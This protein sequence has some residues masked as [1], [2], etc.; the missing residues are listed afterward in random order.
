MVVKQMQRAAE[1]GKASRK[2]LLRCAEERIFFL[3]PDDLSSRLASKNMQY[4]LGKMLYASHNEVFCVFGPDASI[5][6][7]TSRWESGFGYGCVIK[8]FDEGIA[9]PELRP[10]GCG[11]A[12]ARLEEQPTEEEIIEGLS[13][14]E[15]DPPE[16][17]G[18]EVRPDLGEGNHFFEIYRAEYIHREVEKTLSTHYYAILHCSS[19]ERKADIYG[20]VIEGDWID[21]PLGRV[22]VLLDREARDYLRLWEDYKSFCKRRRELILSKVLPDGEVIL[23]KTH[24]GIFGPAEMRLG[25]YSAV[26]GNV[27]GDIFPLTLRSDLP[28][29][30]MKGTRNLSQGVMKKL[31]FLERARGLDLLEELENLNILPHGSGY[32]IM[33]P[34]YRVNTLHR[35]GRLFFY[36]RRESGNGGGNASI[37]ITSPRELPFRYRGAEVMERTLEYELG[38]PVAKLTP[39]QTIKV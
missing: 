20:K 1:I 28:V 33:A 7:N 30:L 14:L 9:F 26:D 25:C 8:W 18:L 11:M 6:R 15:E 21:T 16:L 29:Y 27:K 24:Q 32:E 2:E 22:S 5:T 36:L 17:D 3:G 35:H 37:V 23:D 31:G 38:Y 39:I 12:L 19:P 34:Y 4:G 13:R 10:N